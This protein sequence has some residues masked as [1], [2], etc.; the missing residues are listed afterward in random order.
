MISKEHLQICEMSCVN[1]YDFATL[2]PRLFHF[3]W[4]DVRNVAS[5]AKIHKQRRTRET[6]RSSPRRKGINSSIDGRSISVVLRWRSDPRKYGISA[7]T[8]PREEREARETRTASRTDAFTRGWSKLYDETKSMFGPQEPTE[9]LSISVARETDSLLKGPT[10]I[11]HVPTIS[12][13]D[14]YG[15]SPTVIHRMLLIRVSANVSIT[16]NTRIVK[17]TG[18]NTRFSARCVRRMSRGTRHWR[19][20]RDI[21]LKFYSRDIKQIGKIT[22]PLLHLVTKTVWRY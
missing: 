6:P 12:R 5:E 1:C 16:W 10:R 20:S 19:P 11:G 22:S 14:S 2:Q 15:D 4:K 3:Q 8:N 9:Y 7:T 18:H 13:H 17:I 21:M